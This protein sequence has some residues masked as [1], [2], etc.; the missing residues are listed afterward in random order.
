MHSRPKSR[1]KMWIFFGVHNK[2]SDDVANASS[3]SATTTTLRMH[4]LLLLKFI[5]F[6]LFSDS[7]GCWSFNFQFVCSFFSSYS[8]LLLL[9]LLCTFLFV[10]LM[11]SSVSKVIHKYGRIAA[12]PLIS[13]M[14]SIVRG[15]PR[16]TRMASALLSIRNF[17]D[18][19]NSDNSYGLFDM[20]VGGRTYVCVYPFE[21][22]VANSV[23]GDGNVIAG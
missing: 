20:I 5:S 22:F 14:L 8:F 4:C 7:T 23:V 3:K 12:S 2:L 15:I 19:I 6:F 21:V 17:C 9:V 11:F 16:Y 13:Y 10:C 1:R 18:I